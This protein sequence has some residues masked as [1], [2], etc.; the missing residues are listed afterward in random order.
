MELDVTTLR[1]S[2]ASLRPAGVLD[3][4]NQ[5][6]HGK[7]RQ[8]DEGGYVLLATT[9]AEGP[10]DHARLR[11]TTGLPSRDLTLLLQKLQ[12]LNMFDRMGHGRGCTYRLPDVAPEGGVGGPKSVHKPPNSV[13]KTPSSIHNGRDSV[14]TPPGSEHVLGRTEDV[15]GLSY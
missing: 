11:E 8:L 4:L 15:T 13:H 1:L 2:T 5:R 6:F 10:V 14:Q 7:F 12:R 3:D 9:L